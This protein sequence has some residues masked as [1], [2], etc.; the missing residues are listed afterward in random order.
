MVATQP[1]VEI[2]QAATLSSGDRSAVFGDAPDPFGVA[3]LGLQWRPKDVHF[4]LELRGRPVAHVGLLQHRMQLAQCP[5]ET[6]GLGGVIT[7]AEAR[8]QGYA[9]ALI[10][11][12]IE[13]AQDV[14][15]VDAA[16][17]FCLPDLVDFY[18]RREFQRVT[19]PVFIE[20]PSGRCVSPLQVMVRPFTAEKW[21][22]G[23]VTIGS[24]PW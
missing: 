13:Y 3:K 24:L 23:P 17:L 14:W 18:R 7:A 15:H 19:A 5:L 16:L 2:R 6:L 20:Q 11:R 4:L 12:A 8:G 1:C 22:Q 21:P 10:R 9:T